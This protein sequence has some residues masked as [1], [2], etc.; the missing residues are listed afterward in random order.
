MS[1][2]KTVG[3]WPLFTIYGCIVKKFNRLGKWG[4]RIFSCISGSLGKMRED[5]I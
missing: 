3:L 4:K 5:G 2:E 1:S